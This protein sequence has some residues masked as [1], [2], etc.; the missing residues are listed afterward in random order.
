MSNQPL[1]LVTNDDGINSPGL[2]AAAAAVAD[3]GELL[4]V[5]PSLQQTGAGRSYPPVKDH[6]IHQT[7]ITL[8]A[9][10]STEERKHIAYTVAMSPA[11]TVGI[12]MLDLASR[13][14]SLCVCGINYGEN[15]G[16]GITASG[17]V[18]AAMEGA[19]FGLPALAMSL[20][21]PTKY[22]HSYSKEIDFSTAAYFTRYFAQQVL[23]KGLPTG[24]DL[25]KIDI[26]TTATPETTW[27]T[28]R[29]SRHRYYVPLPSGRTHLSEQ[30]WIGYEI[31]FDPEKLERDSDIY[32]MGVEKQVAVVP[33]TLDFTAHANLS[34]FYGE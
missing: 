28:A 33:I 12:A 32:V 1:I 18:G 6:A 4:I 10:F 31:I 3:L 30:K 14:V 34:D 9:I 23:A 29:L 20:E 17:T 2:H 26:P 8:P 22:H 27:R 16:I 19:L 15:I 7:E 13:P 21:V 11:Q 5:A 24:T 25:L